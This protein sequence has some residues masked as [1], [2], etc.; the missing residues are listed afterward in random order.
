MRFLA[1]GR[2]ADVFHHADGLVLRRYRDG[3]SAVPESALMRELERLGYPVPAVESASGPDLVMELVSGPTLAAQILHGDVSPAEGG[4]ILSE[5]L[6][7]LHALPWPDGEVRLHL[8]LHPFN[9]LM[10]EH[11]PVVI[12]WSNSRIGAPGLDVAMTAL[13]LAQVATNPA[14]LTDDTAL[15]AAVPQ[16][17]ATSQVTDRLSGVLRSLAARIA[18]PYL[19]SLPE[20]E[21]FRRGDRFQSDVEL[22]RLQDA[23]DLAGSVASEAL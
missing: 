2:D 4:G 8:D 20:A 17:A 13:I 11:G 19:D 6:E 23:V 16:G 10:S 14:M 15:R 7:R 3:R 21:A 22:D 9:V 5:L 1:G 18:T 12:D